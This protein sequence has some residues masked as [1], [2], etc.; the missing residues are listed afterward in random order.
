MVEWYYE[1]KETLEIYGES[2]AGDVLFS[3]KA[4]PKGGVLY[5]KDF[6]KKGK[7]CRISIDGLKDYLKLLELLV[8]FERVV[9]GRCPSFRVELT[10]NEFDSE[11]VKNVLHDYIK[12]YRVVPALSLGEDLRNRTKE[13]GIIVDTVIENEQ[14]Q[15]PNELVKRYMTID[16]SL[17]DKFEKYCSD[18]KVGYKIE[19]GLAARV[20]IA[21]LAP[22]Y[23]G[24]LYVSEFC[25]LAGI[26]YW[27]DESEGEMIGNQ[28]NMESFA[29]RQ[30]IGALK[31]R[32]DSG[33]RNELEKLEKF[34]VSTIFPESPIASSIIRESN[35]PE[36]LN[37][38]AL[39]MRD[40]FSKLRYHMNSLQ[41]EMVN[42]NTS[43]E[44][45]VKICAEIEMMCNEL[46]QEKGE[47]WRA[48]LNS[49]TGLL[50]AAIGAAIMPNVSSIQGIVEYL[51]N[52]PYELI[53]RAMRR[54][55]LRVLLEAKRN[56]L[57][58]NNWTGKIASIFR[59][60][61]EEVRR[62]QLKQ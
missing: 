20:A 22:L 60:P 29:R 34:G 21:V 43:I 31:G 42:E 3:T 53:R 46:W 2:K 61:I 40:K 23:G 62:A 57:R 12:L 52:Q 5:W 17:K 35:K 10:E 49:T 28:E 4:L 26:T 39:Q 51:L 41:E 16:R 14:I 1:D 24:P 25:R 9:V 32:L 33:A 13:K 56:F 36:D 47:G 44:Q 6:D 48:I 54:R 50:N 38:I 55:K 45:K 19:G 59:L 37:R 27:L 7:G 8:L 11:G 18:I 30:V 58:S 15:L